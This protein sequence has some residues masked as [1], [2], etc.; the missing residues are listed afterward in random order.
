M[1]PL[2]SVLFLP[3]L[4][5]SFGFTINY[6]VFGVV[7]PLLDPPEDVAREVLEGGVDIVAG[8]RAHLDVLHVVLLSEGLGLLAADFSPKG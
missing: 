4:I 5:P 7:C 1:L 3:I 8:L 6:L 2:A